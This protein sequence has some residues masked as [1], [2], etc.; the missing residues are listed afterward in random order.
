[1]MTSFHNTGESFMKMDF[2]AACFR[3]MDIAPVNDQNAHGFSY[4]IQDGRAARVDSGLTIHRVNRSLYDKNIY[5]KIKVFILPLASFF[6]G[7]ALVSV[8]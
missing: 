3:V 5:L 7:S 1:M 8:P 6:M 2:S 4:K